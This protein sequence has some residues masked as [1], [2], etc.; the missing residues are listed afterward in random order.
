MSI[1]SIVSGICGVKPKT[2]PRLMRST[3]SGAVFMITALGR[4]NSIGTVVSGI[5]MQGKRAG[6]YLT[7]IRS[8]VLEEFDGTVTLSNE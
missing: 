1:K 7:D 3:T 2:Y 5:T 4:Y 6:T 8:D